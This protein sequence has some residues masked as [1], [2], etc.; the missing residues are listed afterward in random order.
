M[1]KRSIARDIAE[2]KDRLDNRSIV[3]VGL[4]GAGKSSIGRRLA[5]R[6]ELN[7]F[8]ADHEIETAAGKSIPEIFAD[9]GE[10]Y[11]RDGE[12]R[13]ISRLL[14]QGPQVLATGGGA[15]MNEETR[16]YIAQKGISLWL[17]ADLALLMKRVMRRDN[18]P[19]LKTEDPH[20]VMRNLIE[21]RHPVYATADITVESRDV[22]HAQMVNDV[23]KALA[24]FLVVHTEPHLE[25]PHD[26]D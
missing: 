21:L 7:F 18:R 22:Q 6:L 20:A 13:V 23:V 4:M 8:D 17:R 24:D 10:T 12:K 3:V 9:H 26:A 2:I 1:A 5:D 25:S 14:D 15:F 19:L 16:A 11:F